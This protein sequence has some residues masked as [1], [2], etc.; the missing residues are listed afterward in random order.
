[1]ALVKKLACL[2]FLLAATTKAP[3]SDHDYKFLINWPKDGTFDFCPNSR[4]FDYRNAYWMAAMSYYAYLN[5][6]YVEQIFRTPLQ[7][8]FSLQLQNHRGEPNGSLRTTGLGW[9]GYLDYFDSSPE[10]KTH[11]TNMDIY[12]LSQN[13]TPDV[14]AFWADNENMVIVAFR[15]TEQDNPL[16]WA[17]DFAASFQKDLNSLPFWR[18]NVH[19]GFETSLQVITPWLEQK[20]EQLFRR[21]PHASNIPVFLTGHSMG[22]A[23]A[24]LVL[25]TW[26]ER[27]EVVPKSRRLNLKAVYTFGSPRIGNIDYARHL[28]E[29]L[30]KEHVGIYRV[31]NKQD[32]VTKAPCYEY[33]HFGSQIQILSEVQGDFP[34]SNVNVLINPQSDDFNH[35]AYGPY[36][37]DSV[38]NFNQ[39]TN[40]HLLVSY[41]S[42]LVSARRALQKALQS[43]ANDYAQRYGLKESDLN[44]FQYP[45]SC[46]RVRL[47]NSKAPAYLQ[48][49]Y[50]T[51]PFEIEE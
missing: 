48:W 23:L 36:F 3:A 5:E 41:Y 16:D 51:L 12:R 37:F 38:N 15:G 1:M 31:T 17:T 50:Q 28:Q 4:G 20:V 49:N 6:D 39:F 35:C 32:I 44:P 21:Y 22:G 19:R 43:Q 29:H 40:D 8:R 7:Q 34:A 42:G 30:S 47:Y 9:Q 24:T 2:F 10:P 27:N 25:T 33:H 46:Q 11:L 26:L 45:Y 18:R 14:Q 13:L